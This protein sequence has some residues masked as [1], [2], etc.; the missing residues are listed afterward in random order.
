[1]AERRAALAPLWTALSRRVRAVALRFSSSRTLKA[2]PRSPSCRPISRPWSMVVCKRS[3]SRALKASQ[4]SDKAAAVCAF[5]TSTR[6]SWTTSCGKPTHS[7]SAMAACNCSTSHVCVVSK[8]CCRAVVFRT[9]CPRMTLAVAI[10]YGLKPAAWP[11]MMAATRT[12]ISSLCMA[13]AKPPLAALLH[14][15]SPGIMPLALLA[16]ASRSAAF[17]RSASCSFAALISSLLRPAASA[18]WIAE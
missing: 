16:S 1:M 13:S 5:S 15:S 3:M 12:S 9:S 7:P 14:A 8:R 6:A 11:S 18:S 17:C 2:P 10:S 4:M